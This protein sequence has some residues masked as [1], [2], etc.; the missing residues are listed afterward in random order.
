MLQHRRVM[1]KVVEKLPP[2]LRFCLS[3]SPAPVVSASIAF[4]LNRIF[5]KEVN[6]GNLDFLKSHHVVIQVKDLELEFSVTLLNQRLLASLD[7]SKGDVCFRANTLDLLLL[8]TGKADPDTLFFRR[9]LSVTGDTDLGL[10]LKNFLDRL[11]AA[12]LLH[13][14]VYSVLMQV[15]EL[16]EEEPEDVADNS[17]GLISWKM[18]N[19]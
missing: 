15:V 3:R 18:W 16:L 2:G 4:W 6:A 13:K 17:V 11:D 10:S 5:K 14:P 7:K 9:R 1:R 19:K 8:I 12:S